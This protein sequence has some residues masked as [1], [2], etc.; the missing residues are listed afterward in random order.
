M[1]RAPR[2]RFFSRACQLMGWGI[3]MEKGVTRIAG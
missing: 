1:R 3:G 2:V